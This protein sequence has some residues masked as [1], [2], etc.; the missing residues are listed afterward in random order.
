MHTDARTLENGVTIESDLCIIGGGAAGITI[1]QE[2]AGSSYEVCVLESGGF[3]HDVETQRL[4]DGENVGLPYSLMGT[5]L[6]YLGGTT[7]HWGGTCRVLDPVDFKARSWVP[8]SGWPIT[9]E[10]LDPFYERAHDVLEMGPYRY[11]DIGFWEK[12]GPGYVRL[13]FPGDRLTNRVFNY[14]RPYGSNRAMAFGESY[15]DELVGADNIHLLT[16]ANVTEIETNANAS[17]VTGLVVRC[18]DGTEFRASARHYVVACGGLENPR[19]LLLSNSVASDGL[20]ND[21]DLVG[22]FFLE[23]PHVESAV[24]LTSRPSPSFALYRGYWGEYGPVNSRVG[25]KENVQEEKGILNCY[26]V[27]SEEAESAYDSLRGAFHRLRQGQIS[28]EYTDEFTEDIKNVLLDI[29]GLLDGANQRLRGEPYYAPRGL[30]MVLRPE[31]APNPDS[32]V[33]LSDERDELGLR[34]VKLDWRL[35]DLEKHTV[36][37]ALQVIAKEFGQAGLG[38]IRMYDW[39]ATDEDFWSR[40]RF[41]VG[42][43]HMGTT[44]MSD[45]PRQGVVD[46]DCT[47]HGI[48]N[49]HIAGSSVFPT[50]GVSNPTLTIIALALRLADHL[51]GQLNGTQLSHRQ[52]VQ[53]Q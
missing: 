5:R 25:L 39:I 4:Y 49:L 21:H 36:R 40:D 34:R 19:L 26:C 35:S 29:E 12:K 30:R 16:Y 31:Q 2:F 32:R 1:A 38:R 17:Q 7:N 50:S 22:R 44:R 15:R 33:M 42:A 24:M 41:G 3:E 51:E 18:L 11:D 53:E 37:E 6:R 43:H 23:H 52:V 9:R 46:K 45:D 14:T 8:H 48:D 28:D 47:V 20:G 27:L 10:E 13:P